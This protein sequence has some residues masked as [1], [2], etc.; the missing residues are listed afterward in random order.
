[1]YSFFLVCLFLVHFTS[2]SLYFSVAH[3]LYQIH[4][5]TGTTLATTNNH[6]TLCFSRFNRSP[7]QKTYT[8]TYSKNAAK[9]SRLCK[10]LSHLIRNRTPALTDRRCCPEPIERCAWRPC[11]FATTRWSSP[12]LRLKLK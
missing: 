7:V 10:Y 9:S 1:M 12:L 4:I 6:F 8:H 2:H 3:R 11:R 5:A